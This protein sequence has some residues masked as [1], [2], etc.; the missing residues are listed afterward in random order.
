MAPEMAAGYIVGVIPS[1]CVT[2]LHYRLHKRKIH[3][4]AF[5]QLQDNLSQTGQFWSDTQSRV[6]SLSESS[7]EQ[8]QA[9]FMKSLKIMGFLFA[10]LS[11][12]GFIFNSIILLSIHK[13]AVSR[14]E[15]KVF[16]SE[17]C[18]RK[19]APSEVENILKEVEA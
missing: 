16:S 19:L 1:L 7:E 9:A 5:R 15:Q 3:K 4:P 17:L 2:G 13:L 10:L 6:L 18:Q 11:W 14:L 8:D 12:A